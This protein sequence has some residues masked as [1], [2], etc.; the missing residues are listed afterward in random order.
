MLKIK[1]ART[2]INKLKAKLNTNRSIFYDKC[3]VI[4]IRISPNPYKICNEGS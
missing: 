4:V 2:D 3:R 1:S